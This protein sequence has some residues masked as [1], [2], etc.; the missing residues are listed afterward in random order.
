MF[1]GA[2]NPQGQQAPAPQGIQPAVAPAPLPAPTAAPYVPEDPEV[3]KLKF[4]ML[5]WLS[6]IIGGSAMLLIV[7]RIVLKFIG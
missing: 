7:W 5:K 1:K 2:F 4:L 6:I 3:E